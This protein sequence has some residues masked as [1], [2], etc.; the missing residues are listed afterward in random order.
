MPHDL[1]ASPVTDELMSTPALKGTLRLKTRAN[2]PAR[3]ALKNQPQRISTSRNLYILTQSTPG[4]AETEAQRVS[5][6][7]AGQC[8]G[9]APLPA[10]YSRPSGARQIPHKEGGKIQEY[11]EHLINAGHVFVVKRT[12]GKNWLC[13]YDISPRLRNVAPTVWRHVLEM[14]PYPSRRRIGD[15]G[16]SSFMAHGKVGDE[17]LHEYFRDTPNEIDTFMPQIIGYM[18]FFFESV[19]PEELVLVSFHEGLEKNAK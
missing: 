5:R 18:K 14:L 6:R 15:G 13:D 12:P 11:A 19:G 3:A 2:S 1:N 8:V 4:V 16:R 10:L 9:P 7:D 17:I